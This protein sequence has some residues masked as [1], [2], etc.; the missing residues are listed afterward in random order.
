M[1]S[2]R[3]NEPEKLDMKRFFSEALA[4]AEVAVFGFDSAGRVAVVNSKGE[5]LTGYAAAELLGT[6]PFPRL[7]GQRAE[8]IKRCWFAAK[9]GTP[10]K[11][12]A[13]LRTRFD[14]ERAVRWH[15]A[16]YLARSSPSPALVVVGLERP[17]V[18]EQEP[19]TPVRRRLATAGVLAAGLAHEIRNPLNGASLH[20]SVLERA[21]SRI[22]DLPVSAAEAIAV[23]RAETKRLS[24]LVT[25]FLE[26][27]R[28]HQLALQM[29]DL[30]EIVRG[31]AAVL[32]R[33]FEERAI[34]LNLETP[35]KAV[36]VALDAEHMK[37]ALINL[38][39]N[40]LE[41]TGNRG[42]IV[43]RVRDLPD[44]HEVDVEDNGAGIVDPNAPIFD[45]FYTT[46][47][48]GTGLGLS[49]VQ[50]VMSDHGGDVVY[51]CEPGR[52]VFTLHLAAESAGGGR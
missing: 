13:S 15:V 4:M 16:P 11:M 38:I 39:R 35:S 12:D 26:V 48:R 3:T 43:L 24:A 25:D 22:P 19:D 5:T 7:F 37:R 29:C 30:N 18:R 28:P 50:R 17:G 47:E 40:A 20:L 34:T 51:H 44:S 1:A 31:A 14:K 45:A 23:L 27:A 41:A 33:E 36:L 8:V 32:E 42:R 21:L 9:L 46:K 49:I 2:E 6:D 52:T 10:V